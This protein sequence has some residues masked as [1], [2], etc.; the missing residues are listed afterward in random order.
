MKYSGHVVDMHYD[1]PSLLSEIQAKVEGFLGESFNHVML[2]RYESGQE[3]IGK[4]RD[5]KENKVGYF[6]LQVECDAH[7]KRL[8]R[9]L[10]A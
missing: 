6:T 1:Y 9:L 8:N 4:H 5:T 2:N 3:Y 7:E 10:S